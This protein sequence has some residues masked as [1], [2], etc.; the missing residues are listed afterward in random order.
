MA[1]SLNSHNLA[2]DTASRLIAL[3]AGAQRDGDCL[4]NKHQIIQA[5]T[6]CSHH[7]I[8]TSHSMTWMSKSITGL[9]LLFLAHA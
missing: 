1:L 5:D 6:D 8:I 7:R 9:G 2:S 4:R 3:S